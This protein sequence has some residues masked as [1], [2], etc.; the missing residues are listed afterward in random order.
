MALNLGELLIQLG[1]DSKEVDKASKKVKKFEDDVRTS[2]RRTERSTGMMSRG[3]GKLTKSINPSTIAIG[4][5]TAAVAALGVAITKSIKAFAEAEVQ[6]V[7]W[8]QL[9]RQTNYASGQTTESLER[10]SRAL[11]RDTL[12][13]ISGARKAATELLTFTNIT[14]DAFERTLRSAQD[15]A[16]SGFGT[17]EGNVIQLGKA[18]QDPKTGLSALTRVGISFNDQQKETIKGL[19]EQNK[20]FEAQAVLLDAIE[21]QS[22]GAGAAQGSTF[23]GTV[24]TLG[25]EFGLFAEELGKFIIE[26]TPLTGALNTAAAAIRLATGVLGSFTSDT[27]RE[28]AEATIAT[29]PAKIAQLQGLLEGISEPVRQTANA[30]EDANK[31]LEDAAEAYDTL[32]N[33]NPDGLF[34]KEFENEAARLEGLFN[35][36]EQNQIRAETQSLAAG[37]VGIGLG[38]EVDKRQEIND[39]I[40]RLQQEMVDA[41]LVIMQEEQELEAGLLDTELE[42]ARA[43][44]EQLTKDEAEQA[45]KRKKIKEDELKAEKERAAGQRQVLQGMASNIVALTQVASGESIEAFRIYQAAQMGEATIAGISATLHAFEEG[46]KWGGPVLGFAFAATAAAATGAMIASIA[47]QKPPGRQFGGA[48]Q[49][50]RMYQVNETG[51][52]EMLSTGGR[53]YLLMGGRGGNVTAAKDMKGGMTNNF[54]VDVVVAGAVD[55]DT[56]EEIEM[57]VANG[58][59]Q[60]TSQLAQTM[61]MTYSLSRSGSL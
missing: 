6:Q 42:N 7:T 20:L 59:E 1:V 25:E 27:P 22:G 26:F 15:L 43:H 60:G 55:N 3:F 12:A 52:P 33:S 28:A 8:Q 34:G 18:L 61:Q 54:K 45:K 19:Q 51:E 9:L 5:A 23:A 53:D 39:E 46:S 58:I 47:M 14:G 4:G 36:A 38:S 50:N 30:L 32:M 48:V 10:F 17:L 2:G 41:R 29:N 49:P 31:K 37:S 35:Q 40:L 11:G 56:I 44:Q 24:D 57:A 13:S 16:A 21:A